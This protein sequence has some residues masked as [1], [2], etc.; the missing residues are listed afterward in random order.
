MPEDKRK[1]KGANKSD[2]KG[3][4]REK[5]GARR[6]GMQQKRKKRNSDNTDINE[7]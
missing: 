7:A 3:R 5:N 2:L 6:K 1:K 4:K